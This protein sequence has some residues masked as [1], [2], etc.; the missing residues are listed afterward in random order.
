MVARA[1]QRLM[2]KNI[3]KQI[4]K[5]KIKLEKMA[6][7]A[8]KETKTKKKTSASGNIHQIG[9]STHIGRM[10]QYPIDQYPN[11]QTIGEIGQQSQWEYHFSDENANG[12]VIM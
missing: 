6:K 9:E 3:L 11:A 5:E 2:N 8:Y 4:A 12:C 1:N 7:T 10:S